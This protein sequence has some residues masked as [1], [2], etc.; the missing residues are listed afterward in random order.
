MGRRRRLAVAAS[1]LFGAAAAAAPAPPPEPRIVTSPGPDSVSV[2]V[3]RNPH[4]DHDE[5]I[6]VEAGLEGYAL[7]TETRSVDLPPGPV[8]IRFEG[9]ASGIQ[10]ESAIMTGVGAGERNQD[11]LLLSRRGLL[12]AYTGQQVLVRRTDR[13][14]GRVSQERARIRSGANRVVIETAAGFESLDCTGLNQALVYPGVPAGLSAKPVLSVTTGPQAGGRRQVTLSYLAGNFDWDANYVA[15]LSPD[16]ESLSLFAWVTLASA[17]DTSFAN[18][19]TNAVAGKV[20]RVRR[21]DEDE[22]EWSDEEYEDSYGPQFHCW[23]SGTTGSPQALPPEL[24]SQGT[25]NVGDALND[26]PQLR[27]QGFADQGDIVVTASAASIARQEDLGDL[28]LYRIPAPVTVASNSRKQVAFLSQPE[29]KG[30]LLYRSKISGWDD[31][32]DP[33]LIFR[34]RNRSA[35]GLGKPLPS[36]QIVLFQKV[37]GQRMLM[38]E[39]SIA[40]KAVDEEVELIIGDAVNLEVDSDTLDE[41]GD[42]ER[43]RLVV[44]NANPFP[45][46]YEAEFS[47]DSEYRFHKFGRR[48]VERDGKKVWSAIVP[49]NGEARLTYRRTEIEQPE[50]E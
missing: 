41:D 30:V 12:D 17:D 2:T 23:P 10:P 25:I 43:R 45:V 16:A 50:E 20:A 44:T 24:L 33:E 6:D 22:D 7:I 11:R 48:L 19:Q 35:D 46:R 4:R 39:T 31:G 34:F 14:T 3:Y 21:G 1:A 27:A 15:E 18:A 13:A 36:G 47:D 40:D 42:W 37:N 26:L 32:D 49:A 9:V 38:G 29:V 8:T 5:P 28:K